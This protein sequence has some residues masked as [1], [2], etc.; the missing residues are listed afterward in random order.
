[1]EL[2]SLVSGYLLLVWRRNNITYLVTFGNTDEK[3]Q[4]RVFFTTRLELFRHMLNDDLYHGI[5]LN[6][7]ILK[8]VKVI[9]A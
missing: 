4:K 3:V 7:F 1:V 2:D 5:S 9:T 8:F 6:L